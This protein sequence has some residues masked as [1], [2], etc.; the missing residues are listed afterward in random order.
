MNDKK[1]SLIVVLIACIV[2]TP[3]LACAGIKGLGGLIFFWGLFC[4]LWWIFFGKDKWEIDKYKRE[5]EK[6]KKKYKTQESIWD[7]D[8]GKRDANIEIERMENNLL[9]D[10]SFKAYIG[11]RGFVVNGIIEIPKQSFAEYYNGY[12]P[13]ANPSRV[14]IE[15]NMSMKQLRQIGINNIRQLLG[16]YHK[17]FYYKIN[18]ENGGFFEKPIIDY[19]KDF[20]EIET[21]NPNNMCAEITYYPELDKNCNIVWNDSD[22]YLIKKEISF[23]NGNQNNK[24][25]IYRDNGII[26][27]NGND[28]LT[29]QEMKFVIKGANQMTKYNTF[30]ALGKHKSDGVIDVFTKEVCRYYQVDVF[31]LSNNK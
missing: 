5:E 9:T 3:I 4:F 2:F 23:N 6:R 29:E 31:N 21:S 24:Y 16:D 7:N 20:R 18:N 28:C 26:V 19:D 15:T 27:K 14:L 11:K 8:A 12:I 30:G 10:S 25:T 13:K 17:Y 22:I 1:E